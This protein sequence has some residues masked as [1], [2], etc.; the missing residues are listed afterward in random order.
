MIDQRLYVETQHFCGSHL[1]AGNEHTVQAMPKAMQQKTP[2][3]KLYVQVLLFRSF[4][5]PRNIFRV[6]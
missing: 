6:R 5:F 2:E 4:G 1:D 3:E